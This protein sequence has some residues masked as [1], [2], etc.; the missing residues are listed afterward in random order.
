MDMHMNAKKLL[1]ALMLCTPL[2]LSGCLVTGDNKETGSGTRVSDET[3]KQIKVN[4]TTEE[5]VRATLGPPTSD[6]AMQS[7]GHILKY[8]YTEKH[9]SSG[10]VFLIFGGHDEKTVEHNAFFEIKT[11]IVTKA[12]RQ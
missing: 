4:E 7:G 5:W 3:F 11:G 2:L 9:E 6:N 10:A 8:T 1:V 12:W